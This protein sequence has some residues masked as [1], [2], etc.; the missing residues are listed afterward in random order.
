METNDG[1]TEEVTTTVTV[2]KDLS[3]EVLHTFGKPLMVPW[4]CLEKT[5]RL[6]VSCTGY[7]NETKVMT[8]MYPDSFWNVVQNGPKEGDTPL[9]PTPT[10][11]EQVLA[12]ANAANS[13]AIEANEAKSDLLTAKENGDFN[14]KDG[15]GIVSVQLT[16]VVRPSTGG[17]GYKVYTITFTDDTKYEFTVE[18]GDDG[19]DGEDGDDGVGIQEITLK[20]EAVSGNTYTVK[21]TNEKTYDFVAPAGPNGPRGIG[22]QSVIAN[23]NGT[24]KITYTD[25][26]TT[27]VTNPT[28]TSAISAAENAA[29]AANAAARN[30]D[31]AASDADTAAN[32][33]TTATTAAKNAATNANNA[34]SIAQDE[35]ARA[36]S[37]ASSATTATSQARSAASAANKAVTDLNNAKSGKVDKTGWTPNK[38]LG[39]DDTGTVVEKDAPEGSGDGTPGEDGGYYTP[40]V[41]QLNA[42]TMR[43]SYAASKAEMA[44]VEDQEITLP[45]GPQGLTGPQGRIGPQGEQ[46]IQGPTGPQGPK[47][48]T[49]DQGPAGSD[50]TN[51]TITGATA[52][53]D[54]NIGTPSVT[55]TMGGTSSARTFAFAFKN[56]KGAKGD[57]GVQGPSGATGAA[58]QSAYDAAKAGGYMDTQANFYADLAAMQGLA[59]ALAAI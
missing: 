51:A 14:G 22:V 10:L 6:M 16:R 47:G 20:S 7:V 30:A 15:R 55:V 59:S 35:A 26:T 40:S 3:K 33:A 4:E 49:G 36:S 43:V 53:V 12:A 37:A 56:L 5:G 17:G 57:T 41:T 13:A 34:A 19:D 9:D 23:A 45:A 21:L 52:T 54:A 39:T 38:Y 44:A 50:G 42:N 29:S 32:R 46:G 28:L 24:W 27:T 18:N 58:G 1:T 48:D 31:Y 2:S 25:G 11:Y 8:T